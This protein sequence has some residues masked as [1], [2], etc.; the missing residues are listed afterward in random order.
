MSITVKELKEF[1]EDFPDDGE[2]WVGMDNLS[3]AVQEM[4]PLNSGRDIL[5]ELSSRA[6][7]NV[8]DIQQINMKGK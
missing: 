2:V 6:F 8:S 5:L 1:L 3:N 7:G 4:T